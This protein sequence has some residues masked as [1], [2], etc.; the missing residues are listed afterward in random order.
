[1]SPTE[2][3]I[4]VYENFCLSTCTVPYYGSTI[5]R[6]NFPSN[7]CDIHASTSS[8]L[9]LRI[10]SDMRDRIISTLPRGTRHYL[11]LLQ[12]EHSSGHLF[13]SNSIQL[14]STLIKVFPL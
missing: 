5:H 9:L 1:M 12:R 2:N 10:V 4:S 7:K 6:H 13:D 8:A 3:D 11:P 14:V